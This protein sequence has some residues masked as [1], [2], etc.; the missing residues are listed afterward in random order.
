MKE[1]PETKFSL[2]QLQSS[3]FV[4]LLTS[5]VK[6]YI[7]YIFIYFPPL[8]AHTNTCIIHERRGTSIKRLY[9]FDALRTLPS[10]VYHFTIYLKSLQKYFMAPGQNC[11]M[12][13]EGH[14]REVCYSSLTLS[15]SGR[16][17]VQYLG[18]IPRVCSIST[19]R[20]RDWTYQ[21]PALLSIGIPRSNPDLGPV[22]FT[23]FVVIHSAV[24][25][26]LVCTLGTQIT[27]RHPFTYFQLSFTVSLQYLIQLYIVFLTFLV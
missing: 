15:V 21:Q 2:F 9:L 7:T 23:R 26:I 3:F 20:P 6:Y 19:R 4:F 16:S 1:I 13:D 25:P 17:A 18:L 27:G 5:N 12:K 24:G 22:I 14:H 11:V 8:Q 10:N